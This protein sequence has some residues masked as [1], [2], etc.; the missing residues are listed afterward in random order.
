MRRGHVKLARAASSHHPARC[1]VH[2]TKD[3]KS[4]NAHKSIVFYSCN[5]SM[6]RHGSDTTVGIRS[7]EN[8]KIPTARTNNK[9]RFNLVDGSNEMISS[10]PRRSLSVNEINLVDDVVDHFPLSRARRRS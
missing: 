3:N 2:I 10:Y 8:K 6:H 1:K 5:R 9:P 7:I 4:I